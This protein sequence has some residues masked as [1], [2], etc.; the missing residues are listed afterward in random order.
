L[1]RLVAIEL[2]LGRFKAA[3]KGQTSCRSCDLRCPK[4]DGVSPSIER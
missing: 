2:K 1:R 4:F 3:H